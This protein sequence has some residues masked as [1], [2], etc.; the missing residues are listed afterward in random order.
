MF[1][2]LACL[3]VYDKCDEIIDA[4]IKCSVTEEGC[5]QERYH[6]R[7]PYFTPWRPNSSGNGWLI[8]MPLNVAAPQNV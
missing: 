5:M 8:T 7:D 1:N 4:T 3:G 2:T 6:E